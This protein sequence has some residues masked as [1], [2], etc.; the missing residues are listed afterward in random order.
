MYKNDRNH[1]EEKEISKTHQIKK[2]ISEK[3]I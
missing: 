3:I 1:Q 2:E